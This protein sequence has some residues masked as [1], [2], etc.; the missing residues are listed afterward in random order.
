MRVGNVKCRVGGPPEER[1]DWNEAG[2]VHEKST[3]GCG[4][5]DG[6]I[7]VLNVSG[8]EEFVGCRKCHCP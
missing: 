3:N 2:K 7:S 1:H 4:S 5:V 8:Y 6:A